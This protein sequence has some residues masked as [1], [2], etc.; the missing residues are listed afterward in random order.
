MLSP[1]ILYQTFVSNTIKE[2]TKLT[3]FI[4]YLKQIFPF[5]YNFYF[6]IYF[7]F[8][9]KDLHIYIEEEEINPKENSFESLPQSLQ[10]AIKNMKVS[11]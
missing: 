10:N 6:L 1:K 4:H 7:Y 2:V 3:S 5:F 11:E 9:S 8:L